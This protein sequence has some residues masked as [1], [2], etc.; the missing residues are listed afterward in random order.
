VPALYIVGAF[1][2]PAETLIS[3]PVCKIAMRIES[4]GKYEYRKDLYDRAAEEMGESARSKGLDAAAAF[5][6]RMRRN[7]SRAVEHPDMTPEL[8]ELLSTPRV[9]LDYEVQTSVKVRKDPDEAPDLIT[10]RLENDR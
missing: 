5:T 1:Q 7:L 6:L 4:T 2:Y 10:H 8:A 3:T 9:R